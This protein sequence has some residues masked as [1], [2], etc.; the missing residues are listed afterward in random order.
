MYKYRLGASEFLC[1]DVFCEPCGIVFFE[2]LLYVNAPIYKKRS[3]NAKDNQDGP[4]AD[5]DIRVAQQCPVQGFQSDSPFDFIISGLPLNNFSPDMVQEIF[6]TFFRLLAPG[7]VLSYFE[8]M[9]VRPVR[10]LLAG[11][12]EKARLAALDDI[13]GPFLS[14]HRLYRSWV[15]VNLPPAWVQHLQKEASPLAARP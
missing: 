5:H 4:N 7:G 2:V 10:R 15:F 1:H 6:E 11:T 13:I 3:G 12:D 8:Y 9:Y 14:Q